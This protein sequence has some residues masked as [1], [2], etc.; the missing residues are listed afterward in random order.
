M[1][2]LA[3]IAAAF[4]LAYAL[5]IAAICCA[6]GRKLN[7]EEPAKASERLL[8]LCMLSP[9]LMLGVFILV[10]AVP[11][12]WRALG[13]L[14]VRPVMWGLAFAVTL[15][16]Q[17]GTFM[18]LKKFAAF[19]DFSV[20]ADGK[21]QFNGMATIFAKAHNKRPVPYTLD[22]LATI[23]IASLFT[24][25]LA[26]GE[27]IAWRG[28]L[29]P[30]LIAEFGPTL[31]I[32]LLGVLWGLW[33]LPLNLA[34]LNDAKNPKLTAFVFFIIGTI[35]MSAVYGWLVL[36]TNSIWPAAVAHATN[37][38]LQNFITRLA[39][40]ISNVP[41]LSIMSAVYGAFGLV[42]FGL[43]IFT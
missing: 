16:Y 35:S 41:Y 30:V 33:H 4:V 14:P 23:A 38:V 1:V 6:P 13:I 34:G 37:N 11:L 18:V 12:D 15:L 22:I 32:L 36:V 3:F 20:L 10:G 42:F 27:E 28:F 39:P 29:Q 2:Y 25:P 43:I 26:L 24:L 21:W 5:Q 9:T 7:S 31:G 40:K 17:G 8:L 19:P